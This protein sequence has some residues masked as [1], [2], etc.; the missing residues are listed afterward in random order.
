MNKPYAVFSLILATACA[1]A[2]RP[3]ILNEL[4]AIR[5]GGSA[6]EAR[7]LVPQADARA[8]K[9]RN[10]AEAA[11]P[12]GQTATSEMAAERAIVAYSDARE[13][14]RIVKAE[15][16]L[17]TARA[18][19]HQAELQLQKLEADQKK[20]AAESADLDA[21]L[22]ILREAESIAE[23]KPS[24]PDRERARLLAAKTAVAQA[25]LLC[26]SAKLLRS[27]A[28]ANAVSDVDAALNELG[29]LGERLGP[30]ARGPAPIREAITARSRCQQLLTDARRPAAM[31]NPVS[32]RPDQL[33]VELAQAGFAP[34]RD[35][36]GIVVTLFDA[37]RGAALE[38]AAVP[39]LAD[40]GRLAQRFEPIPLLV[41]AH[42]TRG[43]P[44]A[45]DQQRGDAAASKLRASGVKTAYVQ[46]VGGRLPIADA[47]EVAQPRKNER[48]E[49][50]F[51]TPM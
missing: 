23:L 35:D 38:Q 51:V 5:S 4:D 42:S 7:Q 10:E 39:R 28:Q 46:A 8:E 49:V 30:N 18:E 15:Q 43:E 19:V 34:S 25:R 1:S 22:R 3:A 41:V 48:L 12:K 45:T 6:R 14:A 21:Q 24:T 37:F 44:T 31:A 50:I 11:W 17:A 2:P 26:V 36:R 13:L 29:P 47:K 16:R 9:L 27:S 20:A 40:L 33:F 32:E